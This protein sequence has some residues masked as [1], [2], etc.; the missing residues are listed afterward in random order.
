MHRCILC[1]ALTHSCTLV[2]HYIYTYHCIESKSHRIKELQPD[3]FGVEEEVTL[4]R[5][6]QFSRLSRRHQVLI[7]MNPCQARLYAQQTTHS[8]PCMHVLCI[9]TIYTHIHTHTAP[10]H[11][12]SKDSVFVPPILAKMLRPHQ[13]EGVLFCY[14]CVMGLRNFKGQGCILADG[15]Y[16]R[17]TIMNG[18]LCIYYMYLSIHPSIYLCFGCHV[19]SGT[20]MLPPSCPWSSSC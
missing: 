14:Q 8:I 20:T 11:V 1:H 3:E 4:V 16:V 13:R 5:P 2:L 10:L 7:K 19:M 18:W 9:Y 15:T 6:G 12:Y 17:R